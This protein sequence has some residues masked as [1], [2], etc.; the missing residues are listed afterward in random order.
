MTKAVVVFLMLAVVLVLSGI[1][2]AQVGTGFT[3]QG[4]LNEGG[5]LAN[6]QYDFEFELFDDPNFIMG[7]PVGLPVFKEDVPVYDGH[8]TVTLDFGFGVFDGDGRWLEIRVRPGGSVGGYTTLQPRQTVTPAPYALYALNGPGSTGFWAANSNHIYNTN[9]GNVGVGTENPSERFVVEGGVSE[10]LDQ[11]NADINLTDTTTNG[12]QSFTVDKTGKLT[13]VEVYNNDDDGTTTVTLEIYQGEGVA[14]ILLYT[15]VYL[16]DPM[17][18]WYLVPISTPLDISTGQKYTIRLVPDHATNSHW[19]S[20]SSD[21]YP[22]G[23]SSLRSEYDYCFRTYVS[24]P[25]MVLAATADGE[26]Y[27]AY[28]NQGKV[29]VG[30]I[31]PDNE[32]SVKGSADFSGSVAIGATNPVNRLSVNGDANFSG[33]VGINTAYPINTLSIVGNA[34]FTGNVGIGTTSPTKKLEVVGGSIKATGGL[35]IETRTDDPPNPA[36]GQIWLRTDVQSLPGSGEFAHI[37]AGIFFMGDH[38]NTPPY[39]DPHPVKLDDF[40]MGIHEVTN[41]K[42]CEFLNSAYG[43][44]TIFVNDNQVHAAGGNEVLCYL[45]PKPESSQIVFNTSTFIVISGRTDHPMSSVT[46][47]GAVAY[48]NWRSQQQGYETCY[49]LSTWEC[50]FTKNGYRLP[51]EAEWEYAARGGHYYYLYPWGSD[52]LIDYTML[53]YDSNNPMGFSDTPY[54][55]PVGSYTAY[56]FGL[57][58][59]AGNVCEWCHDWWSDTYYNTSPI[60]NPTG[61]TSGEYR[62]FRGGYYLS[63]YNNCYI[64]LRYGI[65]PNRIRKHYGFRLVLDLNN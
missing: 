61:P 37:P 43:L 46:W 52:T 58:D 30:T 35:I 50:N 7:T 40:Y 53:N 51:T 15:T 44:S 18:R 1:V 55:T 9:S 41:L 23:K 2:Q 56:G 4:K 26:V 16:L 17:P 3:Y 13:G 12:W 11:E 10:S 5:S 42:Y 64:W 19:C 32:L 29:G 25:G 54:T 34:D 60:D 59:I 28:G 63:N 38:N 65:F 49:N 33:K 6:G 39:E 57:H 36:T 27:L 21:V 14:G 62:V 20:S 48:C 22:G 45:S 47:Y 31:Y 8:F 24:N